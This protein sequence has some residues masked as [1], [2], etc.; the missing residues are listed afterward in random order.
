MEMS[1]VVDMKREGDWKDVD[2]SEQTQHSP[3]K[4]K[5]RGKEAVTGKTV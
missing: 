2:G 1:D 5:K 3:L 4:G